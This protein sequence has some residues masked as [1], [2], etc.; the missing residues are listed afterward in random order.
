ME[1]VKE[2]LEELITKIET[3]VPNNV[4]NVTNV[5][6]V[7]NVTNVSNNMFE[8][9]D[10]TEKIALLRRVNEVLHINKN[11][12][13]KLVFVYSAPKV[14]STSIVSS[15][16]IY[17]INK[18]SIIHIHDEEMLKVLG[19]V[20]GVT[21]ND[22]ILF[23]KYLGR[24]IYVIDIYRSPIEQ[25]ISTYFEKIGS[26]HFNNTDEK[27]NTYNIQKVIL[28]FNK[29][30]PYLANGNHL[31]DKYN[32]NIPLHYPDKDKFLLIKQNGINYISLRL[33]DSSSWGSIL[34]KILGIKISII[35]GL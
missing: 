29:I 21:I 22:I 13:K 3:D 28:R 11:T 16:R 24:E 35:K 12:N 32:I 2:I 27:V 14:G 10:N 1:F 26:Y 15:L 7:S 18:L 19:H 6:N 34:T 20:N 31:I 9:F 4:T 23:N 5:S 8:F 33:M 25:K 30:F 17:G